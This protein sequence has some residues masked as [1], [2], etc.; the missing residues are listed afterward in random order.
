MTILYIIIRMDLE[1]TYALAYG[2]LMLAVVGA[3]LFSARPAGPPSPPL[4]ESLPNTDTVK[5]YGRIIGMGIPFV[6]L[7]AGP[8]ID[9]YNHEFKYSSTSVV[10]AIAMGIG[11]LFQRLIRGP[12]AFLS[13]TTVAT[14][15]MITF[16][17]QD[18][19]VQSS[20]YNFQLISTVLGALVMVLQLVHSSSGP[21]F[22]NSLLN[23]LSGAGLGVGLGA[24]GWS[25]FWT[26]YRSRLPN[27]VVSSKPKDAK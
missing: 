9:I 25:F 6:L 16:L 5:K 26:F 14:A 2:L 8:L 17:L 24:V 23:D 27:S 20:A 4:T 7:A 1:T 18:I 10:G 21:V 12:D 19:W 11:F 13:S 22:S 15:A 3:L